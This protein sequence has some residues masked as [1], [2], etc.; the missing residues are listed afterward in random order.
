[1]IVNLSPEWIRE[2]YMSIKL[3]QERSGGPKFSN[4]D[5]SEIKDCHQ[6]LVAQSFNSENV[7][8]PASGSKKASLRFEQCAVTTRKWPSI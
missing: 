5:M 8:L 7:V 4:C 3:S 1:M 6:S 2:Q